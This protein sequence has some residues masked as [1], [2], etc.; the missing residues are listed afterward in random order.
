MP[1]K[2]PKLRPVFTRHVG[3]SARNCCV[4]CHVHFWNFLEKGNHKE[5]NFT[6]D[7]DLVF[8]LRFKQWIDEIGTN[9]A[10]ILNSPDV[11]KLKL[12]SPQI[13]LLIEQGHTGVT[14]T[15]SAAAGSNTAQTGYVFPPTAATVN[16]VLCTYVLQ[17]NSNMY[18]TD[19]IEFF[20]VLFLLLWKN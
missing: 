2:F 15:I 9:F 8:V 19:F 10:G 17:Y 5:T 1:R 14:P 7:C 6:Y 18:W 4:L 11:N 12:T 3:D 16:Q 20:V 13:K